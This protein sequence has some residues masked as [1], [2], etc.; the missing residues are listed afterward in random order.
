MSARHVLHW[1]GP[2]AGGLF[3]LAWCQGCVVQGSRLLILDVTPQQRKQY[4]SLKLGEEATCHKT[5]RQPEVESEEE[6]TE[7]IRSKRGTV[8]STGVSLCDTEN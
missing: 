7:H 8:L 2:S 6:Y 3:S 1:G 4:G 5:D